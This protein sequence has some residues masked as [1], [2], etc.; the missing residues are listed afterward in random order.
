MLI[1]MNMNP[2][3]LIEKTVL[4]TSLVL[5]GVGSVG[6]FDTLENI[7]MFGLGAYCLKKVYNIYEICKESE[8]IEFNLY[9]KELQEDEETIS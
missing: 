1:F 8:A 2:R 4:T 7:G 3:S 9:L 6:N 5:G